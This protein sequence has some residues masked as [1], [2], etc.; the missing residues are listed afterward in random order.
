MKKCSFPAFW[1]SLDRPT[2]RR[3]REFKGKLNVQPPK[4]TPPWKTENT[5]TV[6]VQP[7]I[8]QC[9]SNFSSSSSYICTYVHFVQGTENIARNAGLSEYALKSTLCTVFADFLSPLWSHCTKTYAKIF[10]NPC[11]SRDRT[12][13][14]EHPVYICKSIVFYYIFLSIVE[15]GLLYIFQMS[16]FIKFNPIL[17]EIF[18]NCCCSTLF[19]CCCCCCCCCLSVFCCCIFT[20]AA[21]NIRQ[22]LFKMSKVIIYI[23]FICVYV[24]SRCLFLCSI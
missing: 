11:K 20:S 10:W 15:S 21:Q 14:S 6:D 16:A 5:D 17:Y 24:C 1:G 12:I 18:W 7:G 2:N 13:F 22:F 9:P 8:V 3:A 23:F 19:C 4:Q